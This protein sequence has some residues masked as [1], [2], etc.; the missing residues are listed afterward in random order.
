[1]QKLLRAG[2]S[3]VHPVGYPRWKSAMTAYSELLV[4]IYIS[5]F[6]SHLFFLHDGRDRSKVLILYL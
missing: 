5:V 2:P 6:L 4:M 1:M 3:F